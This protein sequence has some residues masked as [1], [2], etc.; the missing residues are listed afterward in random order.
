VSSHYSA[1]R[2]IGAQ[3]G[4]APPPGGWPTVTVNGRTW[5]QQ[6][7]L[8]RNIGG[9]DDQTTAFPPHK[10]I[11]NI[12]YV[13][14]KSLTSYLITTP[15]GHILVN[16]TYERNVPVIQKS[17]E[18]LGFKFSDVKILPAATRMAITGG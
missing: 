15:Q 12:Y 5:N 7:L 10:V 16:S 14:T 8:Q 2:A 17:V 11:G 13:G 4:A 6:E 9:P 18:D 1:G 3:R